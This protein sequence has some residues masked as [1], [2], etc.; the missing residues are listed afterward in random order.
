MLAKGCQIKSPVDLVVGLMREFA[1]ALPPVTDYT[2]NYGMYNYLV[3]WVANMQQSIGDPPDVSGWK[4]YYQE[5]QFYEIWINSDTLPKRNQFT[6]TMVVNGYTFNGTKMLLDAAEFAKTLSNPGDPNKLI[7]DL[8]TIMYRM[9]LSATS[10]AQ[11]K[12]R[13]FTGWASAGLL[14]DRCMECFCFRPGKCIQH[15]NY[16]KPFTRPGQVPDGPVGVSTGINK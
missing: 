15:H 14:L 6:D 1:V 9:D 4:A 2:T 10:K 12:K 8:V 11:L 3:S 5:P 13:Y 7:D 16:Q